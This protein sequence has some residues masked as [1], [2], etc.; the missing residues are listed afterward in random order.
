[1]LQIKCRINRDVWYFYDNVVEYPIARLEN[2]GRFLEM[3]R[4]VTMQIS[5]KDHVFHENSTMKE[6]I[7]WIRKRRL[8]ELKLLKKEELLDK[9]YRE[10]E[11]YFMVK[12][13][14]E[15]LK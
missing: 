14:M 8:E 5:K 2:M 10:D 13:Y 11:V 1:M 12:E 9:G 15:Q 6:V 3:M 7:S 4:K